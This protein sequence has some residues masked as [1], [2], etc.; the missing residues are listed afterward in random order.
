VGFRS[1]LMTEKKEGIENKADVVGVGLV[2]GP[3]NV[4]T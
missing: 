2:I 4:Y 1:F 3:V